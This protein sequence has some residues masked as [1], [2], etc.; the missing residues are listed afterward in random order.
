VGSVGLQVVCGANG[1]FGM[2]SS[3]GFIWVRMGMDSTG[4]SWLWIGR[5]VGGELKE[6]GMAFGIGED[7]AAGI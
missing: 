3:S 5:L 6:L 2:V 1:D 7:R 4:E